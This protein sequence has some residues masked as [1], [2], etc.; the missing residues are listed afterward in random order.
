MDIRLAAW[1]EPAGK[2][3][4]SAPLEGNE[5]NMFVNPDLAGGGSVSIQSD[6]IL[7]LG[8]FGC[9]M[10]VADGMGGMN[11]GEVA[12]AIAIETVKSYFAEGKISKELASS[13]Q[14]RK[15]YLELVIKEADIEIKTAAQQDPDKDGMGSTIILA[16]L[17]ADGLTVSWCGDSRAYLFRNE[18]GLRPLSEDHSYVQELVKAKKLEYVDTFNHPQG[19]IITRSLGDP[20]KSAEPETREFAVREGDI[21]I[22]CSDGLSGVLRDRKTKDR[23]GN[24]YPGDNIEDIIR[25]NQTSLIQCRK[26]LFEAAE[27]AD[28]YDNVT[29]VLCQIV[30][31]GTEPCK[32]E[33]KSDSKARPWKA[34]LGVGLLCILLMVCTAVLCYRSGG[35][36]A[37]K[38]L[39]IRVDSLQK[40]VIER[41]SILIEKNNIIRNMDSVITS[42]KPI[43]NITPKKSRNRDH[44]VQSTTVPSLTDAAASKEA[45]DTS[46]NFDELTLIEDKPVCDTLSN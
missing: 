2:Y 14:E 42:N 21:I 32:E 31:G 10:V 15:R 40:V 20:F 37:A 33:T 43:D 19:N 24:Y 41:D 4:P 23:S 18:G 16:W 6:V 1:S 25:N 44:S 26:A 30:S 45:Q 38:E 7:P 12:S 17:A 35:N 11:A 8:E 29:V 9:L 22:L 13:P 39:S 5:D 28:W 36:K 27:K 3:D 34:F 46:D